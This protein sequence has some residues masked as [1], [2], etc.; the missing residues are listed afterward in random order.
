M[1]DRE[2]EKTLFNSIAAM[3]QHGQK[4]AAEHGSQGGIGQT[5][6]ALRTEHP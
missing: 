1:Q 4:M 2:L 3:T 5:T 6:L